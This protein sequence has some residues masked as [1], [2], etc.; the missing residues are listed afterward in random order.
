MSKLYTPLSQLDLLFAA[1]YSVLLDDS[2]FRSE[3]EKLLDQLDQDLNPIVSKLKEKRFGLTAGQRNLILFG[4]TYPETEDPQLRAAINTIV[5]KSELKPDMVITACQNAARTLDSFIEK[6]E[7]P[8]GS[9]EDLFYY[10]YQARLRQVEKATWE[11]KLRLGPAA[12]SYGGWIVVPDFYYDPTQ[13]GAKWLE[14]QIKKAGQEIKRQ[15]RAIENK[16]KEK[17]LKPMPTRWRLKGESEESRVP[18]VQANL[19]S[20]ELLQTAKIYYLRKVRKRTWNQIARACK[21]SGSQAAERH[22]N[23]VQAINHV[24]EDYLARF[25]K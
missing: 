9:K 25:S 6:W 23:F 17:G 7:L 21:C 1:Y 10:H 5:L 8:P 3:I 15:A 11:R 24:V 18:T 2:N 4:G 12:D 22:N 19:L 16:A 13:H 20:E 14:R